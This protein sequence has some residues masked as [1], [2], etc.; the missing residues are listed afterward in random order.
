[1]VTRDGIEPADVG[2]FSLP[3]ELNGLESADMLEAISVVAA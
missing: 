3:I 1:M 2:L